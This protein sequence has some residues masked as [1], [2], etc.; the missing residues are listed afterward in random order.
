MSDS[1][2]GKK[3]NHDKNFGAHKEWE[4]RKR[5]GRSKQIWVWDVFFENSDGIQKGHWEKVNVTR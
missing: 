3:Q 4:A 5:I 2:R 1:R